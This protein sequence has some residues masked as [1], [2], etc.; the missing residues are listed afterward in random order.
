MT[1][2]RN[3]YECRRTRTQRL[4][5][6][7]SRRQGGL[8]RAVHDRQ[9]R[10]GELLTLR[11]IFLQRRRPILCVVEGWMEDGCNRKA[12]TVDHMYSIDLGP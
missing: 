6:R 12:R 8:Q 2:G 4:R 1:A 3:I 11:G 9:E 5:G 10:E 7:V